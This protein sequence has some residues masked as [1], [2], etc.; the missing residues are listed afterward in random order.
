[1]KFAAIFILYIFFSTLVEANSG[2]T[3]YFAKFMELIKYMEE[4]DYINTSKILSTANRL[5]KNGKVS[6]ILTSSLNFYTFK[7]II[8]KSSKS[9]PGIGKTI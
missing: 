6:Q 7:M 4:G 5:M 8:K 1:M 3:P 9:D 2:E